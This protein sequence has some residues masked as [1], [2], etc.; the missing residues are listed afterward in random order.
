MSSNATLDQFCRAIDASTS[1]Q[2]D[3]Y[4]NDGIDGDKRHKGNGYHEWRERL[5]YPWSDYSSGRN[6]AGN[7]NPRDLAGPDNVAAAT[8]LGF[9][10]D[11]MIAVSIALR[12]AAHAGHPA[13]NDVRE[14]NGFDGTDIFNIDHELGWRQNYE[15]NSSH[16]HHVH[17]AWYRDVVTSW[18]HVSQLIPI[19]TGATKGGAPTEEDPLADLSEII[20]TMAGKVDAISDRV[21]LL[22]NRLDAVTPGTKTGRPSYFTAPGGV[23]TP[24]ERTTQGAR[25]NRLL[26]S[27]DG[28]TIVLTL[29]ALAEKV[30][31]GDTALLARM[32]ELAATFTEGAEVGADEGKPV[33]V[34]Q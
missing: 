6:T 29:R 21:L 26:D 15:P 1:V 31:A 2:V 13:M 11:D 5:A 25:F 16:E 32:D 20:K 7:S 3:T 9:D 23:W 22:W 34:E 10:R 30:D 14:V 24:A 4:R 18:D 8:D 33:A 12:D 19:I 27:G 17:I 28:N